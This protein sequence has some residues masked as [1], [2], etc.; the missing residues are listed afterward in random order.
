MNFK[1]KVEAASKELV[2]LKHVKV[3]N[4]SD[5]VFPEWLY[6]RSQ[7]EANQDS[8][9]NIK[10]LITITNSLITQRRIYFGLT[11]KNFREIAAND[12]NWDKPIGLD[13]NA[14]K[15]LIGLGIKIGLFRVY[16]S[17][18][19]KGKQ[20][21]V[22]ELV[23]SDILKLIEIDKAKQLSD[24]IE[25]IM[26]DPKSLKVGPDAGPERRPE[27]V[28]SNKYIYN[29]NKKEVIS[30]EIADSI[31]DCINFDVIIQ[32]LE[33]YDWKPRK[34]GLLT[35]INTKINIP[36]DLKVKLKKYI[37]ESV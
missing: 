8:P 31:L 13:N 23:D 33:K 2:F 12:N 29:S 34:T 21:I 16:S 32:E 25:Y 27:L 26:N 36:F 1:E 22:F 35:S 7:Y 10:A 17:V 6:M 4:D 20:R 24:S 18:V 15:G 28:Y 11:V 37:S 3:I 9:W 5:L 30:K 19:V 14:W